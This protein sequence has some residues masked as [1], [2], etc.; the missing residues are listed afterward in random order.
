MIMGEKGSNFM[1]RVLTAAAMIVVVAACLI[2]SPY[3][4]LA[5]TLVVCAGAMHEFFGLAA[6]K[7]GRPLKWYPV[8]I[9]MAAISLT[10]LIAMG[11]IGKSWLAV[12]IPLLSAVFVA[13]LYRKQEDPLSN[14]S[15]ALSG[16]IYVAAP[17]CLLCAL[18]FRGGSYSPWLTLCIIGI[19]AVNDTFAYITGILIGR[20][21][22][23]ERISPKKSWEGF[24]GGLIFAVA[25]AVLF[26]HLMGG[27]LIFWG[28]LGLIIVAGAVFG[29][30]IESM[31]KR[32][33]GVK[34]SGSILP[35]HGGFLD[36]I[37]SLLFTVPL[38][39]A[40]FSIFAI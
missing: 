2:L 39:Y 18:A 3:S 32:S 4:F 11:W 33:A 29:D 10:F 31:L 19:V 25:A 9:G 7:G 12:L 27:N 20:H 21:K 16:L 37:D 15:T 26:G 6:H 40:Y 30:F 23:F 13:E 28:G 17:L 35:G 8:I 34:D 1:V 22:I 14:I 24:F 5:I 36:R 38:V